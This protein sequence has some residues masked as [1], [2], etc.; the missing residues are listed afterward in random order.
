MTREMLDEESS[1]GDREVRDL[2]KNLTWGG[3]GRGEERMRMR[4]REEGWRDR[5][6]PRYESTERG[7]SDSKE[8]R[9]GGDNDGI[10]DRHD[11]MVQ[12]SH[13]RVVSVLLL[14][15]MLSCRARAATCL[16]RGVKS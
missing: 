7:E 14:L 12:S 1:C 5:G 3:E 16:T 8:S 9:R 2:V 13:D 11:V 4:Q 6:R 10:S 15:V